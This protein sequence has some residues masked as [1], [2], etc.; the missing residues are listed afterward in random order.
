[1]LTCSRLEPSARARRGHTAKGKY[2]L[3]LATNIW[4]HYIGELMEFNGVII[5][6][7][8]TVKF[9]K[10]TYVVISYVCSEN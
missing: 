6:D 5:E 3:V 10:F 9:H 7:T 4:Y 8:Y 1:M 2:Y